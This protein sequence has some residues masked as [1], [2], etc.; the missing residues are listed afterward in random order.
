MGFGDWLRNVSLP[1]PVTRHTDTD[2]SA[3]PLEWQLDAVVWHQVH[4][5]VNPEAV[6]AIYAALDL[7]ASSIAQFDTY[8]TT[9]LSRNPDQ[10]ATRYDFLFE[11][12]WSLAYHGD[13][14]WLLTPTDRGVE[15]MQVLDPA[16]V[17]VSW[18][19]GM[20]RR[21]REYRWLGKPIPW[22]WSPEAVPPRG[23][24]HLR[25]HPEPGRLTGLSPIEAA[26]LTWD[27]AG[28]SE[29][30]GSTLF[31]ASGV[32]SGVITA[33]DPANRDRVGDATYPMGDRPQRRP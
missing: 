20:G 13:A 32:P 27:G 16:D 15:T 28:Y 25:F 23:I 26:R 14:Y 6:P 11:T 18:N 2:P 19:S 10:F 1:P 9:P 30:W 3:Y 5:G 21:L 24:A 4:G 8:E 22:R 31:G 17:D 7:I 12:A 29:R 33:P